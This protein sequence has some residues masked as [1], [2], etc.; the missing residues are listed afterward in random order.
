MDL[1]DVQVQA[2]AW[3]LKQREVADL[4]AARPMVAEVAGTV[5]RNAADLGELQRL[6]NAV[7][8]L[9]HRRELEA[10]EKASETAARAKRITVAEAAAASGLRQDSI[11]QQVRRGTRGH[12]WDDHG[13]LWVDP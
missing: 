12:H 7:D 9:E 5:I 6:R 11:R 8:W 2:L 10:A 1:T 4:A 13:L 3:L